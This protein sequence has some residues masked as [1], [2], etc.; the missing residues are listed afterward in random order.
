[1]SSIDLHNLPVATPAAGQPAFAERGFDPG[2]SRD[3]GTVME[4]LV[5]TSGGARK[6]SPL[7]QF[8]ALPVAACE[9]AMA[10]ITAP[11]PSSLSLMQMM[12]FYNQKK[13]EL[14]NLRTLQSMAT[15]TAKLGRKNLETVMNNK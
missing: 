10:S 3:F 15:T 11:A 2:Q 14:Y 12:E 4:G 7:S 9:Q 8:V 6:P 1:M 5:P 13:I